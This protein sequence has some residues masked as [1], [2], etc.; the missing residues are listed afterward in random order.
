MDDLSASAHHRDAVAALLKEVGV[1]WQKTLVTR[2]I[3]AGIG[4][5]L[6]NTS[7]LDLKISAAALEEMRTA[8]RL[9][10]PFASVPKVTI[11]GSARTPASDPRSLQAL[12]VSRELAEQ[13]W[14]VVTGAG[15]G[16]MESASLGAGPEQS[17]GV[18]IRLP[19]EER[20][21]HEIAENDRLVSMKYFFTRKLM[22]VKESRGF[23]CL[24]GGYGTMDE[25][26][27]LLT[28]Q[29]TGKMVPTP[30]VL[31]DQPGG[32]FWRGFE[33]FVLDHLESDGMIA[34]G[35]LDRV[36]ITESVEDTATEILGFWRNYD[37]LRWVGE[38]LVLRLRAEPS[39]AEV[40]GLNEQFGGLLLSGQIDVTDPL[41]EEVADADHLELPRL[42]LTLR[43]RA[44]GEL[45]R[46]IRA[47]NALPSA[48][49]ERT[50]PDPV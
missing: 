29:Q 13:G 35:D 38:Q 4:L 41:P 17:L 47:I 23:V 46:M 16:I 22:L 26:F 33:R 5:G 20:P 24:P 9:F 15:P 3:D 14:M 48:P 21:S 32:T 7:R 11:F 43:P 39:Q 36:L 10:A 2:I 18:S 6:D 19:F 42:V 45:H 25:A 27:E 40:D 37:S 12:K 49:S 30:I 1:E 44:V 28:L 31:L 50:L 8:Y 34:K